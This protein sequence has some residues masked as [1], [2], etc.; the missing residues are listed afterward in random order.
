MKL[1]DTTIRRRIINFSFALIVAIGSITGTLAL[2]PS[3]TAGAVEAVE[4]T[5][6]PTNLRF[7]D[8]T[9]GNTVASGSAV[10]NT[11]ITLLWDRVENAERYRVQ[12]KSPDGNSQANR[13]T[14]WYTFALNDATRS[15]FFGT[16]EGTWLYQVSTKDA[17]TGV[18]S[19]YSN[20]VSL[21]FDTTPPAYSISNITAGQRV[22]TASTGALEVRGSFNDN[23]D[24][25]GANYI[26]LQLVKD[27]LDR[28]I[29]TKHGAVTNGSLGSFNVN[30]FEKGNYQ[31]NVIGAADALGNWAPT[32]SISFYLDPQAPVVSLGTIPSFAKGTIAIAGSATDDTQISNHNLSLYGGALDLS[33]GEP[34]SNQRIATTDGVWTKDGTLYIPAASVSVTRNL[35]TKLLGDG[36]YQVRF[37]ARDSAGQSSFQTASFVVDNTRPELTVPEVSYVGGEYTFAISQTEANPE[38]AYVEYMRKDAGGVYR[39]QTGQWF[40]GTNDLSYTVDTA[41]YAAGSYQVKVSTW[42]KAGHQNGASFRFEVDNTAPT[43]TI[44]EGSEFTVAGASAYQK[45]SFKLYDA[46][47]GIKKLVINGT[48]KNLGQGPWGDANF[49]VPGVNG[50]VEG[51]NTITLYDAAGNPSA[52]LQFVID[53]IAPSVSADA[54]VSG[55][56]LIVTPSYTDETVS[57]GIASVEYQLLNGAGEV[58]SAVQASNIFDLS[59]LPSGNYAARVVVTDNAGNRNSVDTNQGSVDNTAPVATINE[60]TSD[61]L[62]PRL[63]GTVDESATVAITIARGELVIESGDATVVLIDGVYT[64]FYD[65]QTELENGEYSVIASATDDAGN[66]NAGNN[67]VAVLTVIIPQ[68]ELPSTV[69]PIPAPAGALPESGQ[70]EAGD[71]TPTVTVATAVTPIIVG[72]AAAAVLGQNT[73]TPAD[74]AVEGA[75][76]T[77][78]L[79]SPAAIDTDA[80]D[81]TILGLAWYWWLLILAALAAIAG[82]VVAAI[83]RRQQA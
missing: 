82:W 20:A 46:G 19:A 25:S 76:T 10:K 50:V 74:A 38:K 65:V 62:T 4:T 43:L 77:D 51:V 60:S 78:P 79:T 54:V 83:R 40:Y 17:T 56:S 63:T 52:P 75:S 1:L 81:G 48:E 31:L 34:R 70:D 3:Q 27:G 67:A 29:I 71:D 21:K 58:I 7:V 45:I 22:G 18:W 24:G 5:V 32:Q 72:P 14:G 37:A 2:A 64:W 6:A 57:A 8:G 16:Q 13:Q 69:T 55:K 59:G 36:T 66:F 53:T 47:V 39:K 26:T 61:T 73:Q 68:I 41:A 9:T 44:K 28:G 11:N 33:D 12:V 42:D 30:G 49:L 35:N 80:T 23:V 15:G